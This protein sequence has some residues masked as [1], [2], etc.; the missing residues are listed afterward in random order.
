M[1]LDVDV[2]LLLQAYADAL[3]R[4]ATAAP[5]LSAGHPGTTRPPSAAAANHPAAAAA[6]LD[7]PAVNVITPNELARDLFQWVHDEEV[8]DALYLQVC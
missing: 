7:V 8:V 2:M 6:V 4:T 1:Q 5:G 3:A